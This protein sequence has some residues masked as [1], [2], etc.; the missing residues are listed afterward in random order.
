M[1]DINSCS[2]WIQAAGKP[3]Y[4]ILKEICICL[5]Y[6][7]EKGTTPKTQGTL[8]GKNRGR[9]SKESNKG[10]GKRRKAQNPA[11]TAPSMI[12]STITWPDSGIR[13]AE[14]RKEYGPPW[15]AAECYLIVTLSDWLKGKIMLLHIHEN[16]HRELEDCWNK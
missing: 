15:K 8:N 11:T 5:S 9:D 7:G 6:S 1:L 13:W 3:K 2:Q 16:A 10:G 12:T 14:R 4:C